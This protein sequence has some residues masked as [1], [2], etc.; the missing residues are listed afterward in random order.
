M[1]DEAVG[2][3]I[4]VIIDNFDAVINSLNCR[5]ECH[6]LAMISTQSRQSQIEELT[7]PR[8]TKFQ[9]KEPIDCEPQLIPYT[10]PSRQ[11]LIL[12][13]VR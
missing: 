1:S 7:I 9:M 8:L 6:V 10:G 5:E 11:Q 3:L 2:G 4:Q 13:K 12:N